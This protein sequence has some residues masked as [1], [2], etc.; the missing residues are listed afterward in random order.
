MDLRDASASKKS[1]FLGNWSFLYWAKVTTLGLN[2]SQITVIHYKYNNMNTVQR[3]RKSWLVK[4]LTLSTISWQ[5]RQHNI[6][7]KYGILEFEMVLFGKTFPNILW[8]NGCCSTSV[9]FPSL[10]VESASWCNAVFC[11]GFV[12]ECAVGG[13]W[14][15]WEAGGTPKSPEGSGR[16]PAHTRWPAAGAGDVR[17]SRDLSS[18]A[19]CQ[20]RTSL[21]CSS[22]LHSLSAF[23]LPPPSPTMFITS[24]Y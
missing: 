20:C 17:T 9:I 5:F 11:R 2:A 24:S 7:W 23:L 21:P 16:S 15:R 3:Y 18:G 19:W 13:R 4:S 22:A 14:H 8:W 12:A 1:N 6:F 10:A